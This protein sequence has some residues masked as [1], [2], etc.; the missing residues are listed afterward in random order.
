MPTSMALVS[1]SLNILVLVLVLGLEGCGWIRVG[2]LHGKVFFFHSFG[3]V[4]EDVMLKDFISL[5]HRSYQ[6]IYKIYEGYMIEN[7]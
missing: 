7:I 1:L 4:R 3:C 6:E 5:C 2:V